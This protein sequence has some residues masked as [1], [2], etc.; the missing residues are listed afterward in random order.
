MVRVY[1]NDSM[2]RIDDYASQILTAMETGD[3]LY[4]QLGAL[5]KLSRLV[6]IN[7]V[8]ARRR[9]ADRIIDAEKYTC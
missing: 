5:R 4:T 7:T 6:P 3:M 2:K 8:E 9:I 1:I